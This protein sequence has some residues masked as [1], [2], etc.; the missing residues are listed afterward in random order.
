MF[1][2]GTPSE[3]SADE[4]LFRSGEGMVGGGAAGSPPPVVLD[5][6]ADAM[7]PWAHAQPGELSVWPKSEQ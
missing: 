2:S 6:A 4:F 7:T 1:Y 5:L 3:E